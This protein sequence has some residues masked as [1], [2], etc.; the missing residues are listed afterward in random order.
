MWAGV[1]DSTQVR[2]LVNVMTDTTEFWRPFGV[3]S[4]SAKDDY[5]NPIGY[6]NGPV[7]VQ[8]D[9]LLFRGLLDHG[10]GRDSQRQWDVRPNENVRDRTRALLRRGG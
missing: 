6:W 10:Q 1:A 5:Y 4:L 3:P 7:W 2:Q 9:Y 8:W